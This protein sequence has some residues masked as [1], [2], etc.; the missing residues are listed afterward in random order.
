MQVGPSTVQ[1][2]GHRKAEAERG[3]GEVQRGRVP[4]T[5]RIS[6]RNYLGAQHTGQLAPAPFKFLSELWSCE[7]AEIR[8]RAAVRAEL[9]PLSSQLA[10]LGGRQQSM[11]R[12]ASGLIP[13]VATRDLSGDHEH[14][15]PEAI[16]LERRQS[17]LHQ[18]GITVVKRQEN[19]LVGQG[20]P[21]ST[22]G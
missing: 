6:E 17:I 4:K 21:V 7:P 8:M 19:R 9:D 10:D 2:F 20:G 22:P 12:R 3:A 15:R 13:D 1:A 18:V 16:A 11:R 14:R 5:V